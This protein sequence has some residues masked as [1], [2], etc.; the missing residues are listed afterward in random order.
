MPMYQVIMPA[1]EDIKLIYSLVSP[2]YAIPVH[3]EYRHLMAQASI[4]EELGLTKIIFL[5]YLPVMF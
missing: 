1:R 5:S 2:K 3:G 4:A